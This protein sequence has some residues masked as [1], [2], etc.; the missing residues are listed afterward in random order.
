MDK[1]LINFVEWLPENSELFTGLSIEETVRLVNELVESDDET[2]KQ[3]V[4]QYKGMELFK[5][6][7][8]L[9][10][11]LCLKKGG[12]M[13]CGCEKKIEKAQP[14]SGTAL[15]PEKY[16][17]KTVE[18]KDQYGFF[19]RMYNDKGHRVETL[20]SK[21]PEGVV[22]ETTRTISPTD[23]NYVV[24]PANKPLDFQTYVTPYAHSQMG[25]LR[26]LFNKPSPA[27]WQQKFDM[28]KEGGELKNGGG[29]SRKKAIDSADS[30]K[31][32]R[33]QYRQNKKTMRDNGYHGKE[34]KQ[35][36]RK[37]TIRQSFA[38]RPVES[39]PIATPA[40]SFVAQVPQMERPV[41][42]SSRME[43]NYGH[44]MGQRAQAMIDAEQ[45]SKFS[46]A[47]RIARN[48]GLL[49]FK[50]N[51]KKY[52]TQL[53][54][55]MSD[56]TKVYMNP[57]WAKIVN[58]YDTSDGN[59]TNEAIASKHLED[60]SYFEDQT[61]NNPFYWLGLN[62]Y[63][64]PIIPKTVDVVEEIVEEEPLPKLN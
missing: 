21:T 15:D 20:S 36:A 42:M 53:A 29:I 44:L 43:D 59:L 13:D 32:G 54:D 46:D 10:Y 23:T 12:P 30:R 17:A 39:T 47:F 37:A 2:L 14:G 26:R 40:T 8:K 51:G 1:E 57:H 63:L 25:F 55:P 52:N 22:M 56:F 9:D 4:K 7:G 35:A 28:Y 16:P 19:S 11:L 3:L 6:G 58:F 49:T 61:I 24:G 18:R 5:K 60:P 50:W 33:K 34:M 45:A 64:K 38:N 48:A 62:S 31:E 41:A 27:D